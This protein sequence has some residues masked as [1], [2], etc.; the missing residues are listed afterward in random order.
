[1]AVSE[2]W[3]ITELGFWK[4]FYQR[5]DQDSKAYAEYIKAEGRLASE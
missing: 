4:I 2:K 1:M 3:I 5:K